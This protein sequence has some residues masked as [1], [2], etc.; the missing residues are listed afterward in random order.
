MA[1]K[2]PV[3]GIGHAPA[4]QVAGV[5][6]VTSSVISGT[7]NYKFDQVT[8]YVQVHNTHATNDLILSFT[9]AGLTSNN[10]VTIDAGTVREFDVRCTQVFLSESGG[11]STT[12]DLLVGLTAIPTSQMPILTASN[13]FDGVG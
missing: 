11:T 5:P 2:W 7:P 9:S 10:Y 13:G 1:L 3:V 8:K 12:F 4:Y 6:W